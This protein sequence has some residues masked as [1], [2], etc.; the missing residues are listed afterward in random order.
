MLS[1]PHFKVTEWFCLCSKTVVYLVGCYHNQLLQRNSIIVADAIHINQNSTSL[2]IFDTDVSGEEVTVDG[3]RIVR[4]IVFSTNHSGN[5]KHRVG[6]DKQGIRFY[7]IQDLTKWVYVP[8]LQDPN[9][10]Y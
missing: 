6:I 7:E 4:G 9:V 8:G 10:R 2:H 5:H 1:L 3:T